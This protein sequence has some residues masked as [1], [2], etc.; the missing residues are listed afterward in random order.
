MVAAE[1]GLE[2]FC[3]GWTIISMSRGRSGFQRLPVRSGSAMK[4]RFRRGFI[5]RVRNKRTNRVYVGQQS[6]LYSKGLEPDDI[7][8]KRYWT[9]NNGLAQEWKEHP[10]DF[11]W[12][13]LEENISQTIQR[14]RCRNPRKDKYLGIKGNI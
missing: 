13:V 14:E 9:S 1:R 6:R 5:Y 4:K 10:D 3:F 2:S 8:G 12:E 11:E 7:M